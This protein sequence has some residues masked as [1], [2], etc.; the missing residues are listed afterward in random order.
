[1]LFKLNI[2]NCIKLVESTWGTP[3]KKW[4]PT[5]FIFSFAIILWDIPFVTFHFDA[6]FCYFYFC[7]S[8]FNRRIKKKKHIVDF[9]QN[10]Q[11]TYVWLVLRVYSYKGIKY[12][13]YI[14]MYKKVNM[15]RIRNVYLLIWHV[16]YVS[17]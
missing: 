8:F 2:W 14:D 4:E 17:Y 5:T 10:V 7:I 11:S 6:L 9:E 13:L 16:G 3:K 1:M 12:E 15:I